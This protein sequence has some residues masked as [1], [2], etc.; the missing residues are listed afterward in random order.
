MKNLSL[1]LFIVFFSCSKSIEEKC[2]ITD[3]D[4]VFEAYKEKEPYTVK[5]ILNEKP[6]YLEIV[7]LKKYRSFKKDSTESDIRNMSD[8]MAEKNWKSHQEEFK[9]FK[10]KFSDQFDFSNKQQTG[11]LLYALGRN[12]LGYWLLRIENN[13]P[14]AYFLGLSF[15]HYYINKFQENPILKDGFLQLEG[16]LVKIIK[17]PGLPGYDDY[18]AI[19][20]GKLF[21]ISLKDL[22]KDSDNDGYNDI[23]ENS[24][25]LNVHNKDTDGDGIN[26]FEDMNPMFKSEKNKFSQLYEML[27]PK[28]A[29]VVNFKNIHYSFTVYESDCDYFHQINPEMRVLFIPENEKDQT[30]Y[31]KVTDITSGSI[32][33][34][35]KDKTDSNK[36]YISE[37][38]SSGSSDYSAEYKNG[39]WILNIIGSI[40]I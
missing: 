22:M 24:V 18:S 25:G 29:D 16:S 30:Q 17:V 8:E 3:K 13:K 31:V 2:F 14:F 26:D 28:Y 34:I 33:K 12:N 19:E 20:D 37:S 7:N 9:I 27:L 38:W 21:K 4:Q 15:S 35:K 10:D 5:Q 39:K 36:F 11:N 23:F 1:L 40:N 32:S 6:D